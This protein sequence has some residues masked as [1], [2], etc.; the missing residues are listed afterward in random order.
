MTKE[1]IILTR[2]NMTTI[3]K[4]KRCKTLGQDQYEDAVYEKAERKFGDFTLT[5]KIFSSQSS[6]QKA[7]TSL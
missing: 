5:F 7:I 4:G 6:L 2:S 3:V 1:D